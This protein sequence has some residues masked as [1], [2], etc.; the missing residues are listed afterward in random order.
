MSA[1][2]WR[3]TNGNDSQPTDRERC[4]D[5]VIGIGGWLRALKERIPRL[6]DRRRKL[7][8]SRT[9]AEVLEI[10]QVLSAVG[11][12]A[13]DIVLAGGET[14]PAE[15]IVAA[16]VL[17]GAPGQVSLSVVDLGPL[18][19]FV[20]AVSPQ[21]V[22]PPETQEFQGAPPADPV[23][24]DTI[25]E[26]DSNPA[27]SF[28]E[29]AAPLDLW[30]DSTHSGDVDGSSSLSPGEGRSPSD[31]EGI[32]N[33]SGIQS[34]RPW[35]SGEENASNSGEPEPESFSGQPQTPHDDSVSEELLPP[36]L[37]DAAF[38]DT[39]RLLDSKP[40]RKVPTANR[41]VSRDS[42]P[43]VFPSDDVQAPFLCARQADSDE[44][45]L[46]GT[47][48][49]SHGSIS[50]TAD[51]LAVGFSE[52]IAATSRTFSG[53]VNRSL[54]SAG[55]R[56]DRA[57]GLPV[58][59]DQLVQRLF[60]FRKKSVS[61]AP[62]WTVSWTSELTARFTSLPLTVRRYSF[63]EALFPGAILLPTE[64]EVV[65][66]WASP[67][68]ANHVRRIRE[69]H[70]LTEITDGLESRHGNPGPGPELTFDELMPVEVRYSLNPRGPP[71]YRRDADVPLAESNAPA[72]QLERLKYSIAPRG[73]SLVTVNVQSPG[74]LFSSG[75][76]I[77]P[78]EFVLAG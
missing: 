18:F 53:F 68:S 2:S 50:L 3:V 8:C 20:D 66:R 16:A 51:E 71:E 11:V 6:G 30:E 9:S 38:S 24:P 77:C 36:D 23:L 44:I 46:E 78:E 42:P 12:A 61:D 59:W 35:P 41:A 5:P 13:G 64:K 60:S 17:E 27:D 33:S 49:K 57:V 48:T 37:I 72:N 39:E 69:D 10:R 34:E 4:D 65:E 43:S 22:I 70:R 15:E 74:F 31:D 29:P 25:T 19:G 40:A 58:Q 45:Q 32:L 73:P 47:Q 7:H 67:F 26:P 55:A 62:E 52:V 21:I 14:G 63:T 28:T 1:G 76:R 56:G 54:R 75:P